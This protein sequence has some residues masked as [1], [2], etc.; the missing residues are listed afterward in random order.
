LI[1]AEEVPQN[2]HEIFQYPATQPTRQ[3]LQ[4]TKQSVTFL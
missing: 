3:F 2:A 1:Y 4:L